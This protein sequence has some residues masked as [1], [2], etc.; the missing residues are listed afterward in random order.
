MVT[1]ELAIASAV[2]D[3]VDRTVEDAPDE[4]GL[5]ELLHPAAI[6][7][8]TKQASSRVIRDRLNM[9]RDLSQRVAG[10]RRYKLSKKSSAIANMT[11]VERR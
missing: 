10:R 9:V 5:G 2:V 8:A 4:G 3:V 6:S 7:G 11:G 1:V